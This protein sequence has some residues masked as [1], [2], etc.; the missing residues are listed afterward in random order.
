[1]VVC[2]K[3]YQHKLRCDPGE[4]CR[5]C[6]AVGRVYKRAMCKDYEN[7]T[8][9]RASCLRAHRKDEQVYRNIVQAGHMP[10]T[11]PSNPLKP[12]VKRQRKD[13]DDDNGNGGL[14]NSRVGGIGT[15]LALQY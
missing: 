7:G 13:D 9:R 6:A 4:H 3:C 15:S 1:V 10:R 11:D 8:C 5:N 2:I 14:K 12:T